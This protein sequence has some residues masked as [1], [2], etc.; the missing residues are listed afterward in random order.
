MPDTTVSLQGRVGRR[1][2]ETV[3]IAFRQN[4]ET[5]TLAK[6]LI[7]LIPRARAA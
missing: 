5:L 4:A 7:G 6:Q 3:S 2:G 1:D